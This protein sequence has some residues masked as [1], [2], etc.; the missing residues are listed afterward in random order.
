MKNLI[1]YLIR[2]G[3]ITGIGVI[4]ALIIGLLTII[5]SMCFFNDQI[6]R[7]LGAAIGLMFVSFAGY[8]SRAK[9]LGLKPFDNSYKKA[10]E[11]YKKDDS[12]SE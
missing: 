10:R 12:K 9:T 11:S 7:I 4:S 3:N 8:S 2:D 5:S 6:F 1:C